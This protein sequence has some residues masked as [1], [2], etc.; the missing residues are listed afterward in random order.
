MRLFLLPISTRRSLIYCQPTPEPKSSSRS[1]YSDRL[2]KRVTETWGR[3]EQE[4]YGLKKRIVTWGNKA[5]ALEPYEGVGL[6]SIPPRSKRSSTA[7]VEVLFP[8]KFVDEGLVLVALN[9]SAIRGQSLYLKR[10]VGNFLLI[11]WTLPFALVPINTIGYQSSANQTPVGRIPNIPFFFVTFKAWNHWRAYGGAK[12]LEYLLANGAIHPLPSTELDEM[13]ASGLSLA[14]EHA[15]GNLK[16]GSHTGQ[17]IP[18]D[19]TVEQMFLTTSSAKAI[20]EHY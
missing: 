13:C 19:D 18:K 3:W 7:N 9:R 15:G 20:V 17:I 10:L 4:P 1:S 6:R 14:Q 2:S 5:L 11:P 8:R 12:Q 16:S